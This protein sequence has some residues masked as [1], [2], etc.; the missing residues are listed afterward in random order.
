MKLNQKSIF[1]L[2]AVLIFGIASVALARG[3]WGNG[4][5]MMGPGHGRGQCPG[6]GGQ[7]M[8]WDGDHGPYH[9]RQGAAWSNLSD[10]DKA[11]L[12]ASREQFHKDTRELRD[13]IDE[14][15][16]TLRTEMDKTNPDQGKVFELQKE[17]SSLRGEFGQK[18]LTHRLEVRKMFPDGDPAT[19]I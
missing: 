12:N 9:H 3:G 8:G 18:A 11:K 5:H 14:K 7:M 17:I 16:A 10:A 2:A 6:Y 1:G 19:G 4:G 15:T 13:R